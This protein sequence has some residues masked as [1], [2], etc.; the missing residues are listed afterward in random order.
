MYARL[1]ADTGLIDDYAAACAAHAADLKQAAA[2]LSSAGAESGA[3]F[4]PVGARFL[5]SLARAARD[6]ADGVAQLS[7]ALA[8]GATAAAGTSHAYTVADDAAA[9]RIAR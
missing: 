1:S 8:S 4:G 9:A 2:A 6:D 7:R 5:A 3:M